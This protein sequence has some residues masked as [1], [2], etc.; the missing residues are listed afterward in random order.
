MKGNP[1]AD[2]ATWSV[3]FFRSISETSAKGLPQA[4]D[5]TKM[6]LTSSKGKVV[7]FSIQVGRASSCDYGC[8]WWGMGWLAVPVGSAVCH[9]YEYNL[10]CSWWRLLW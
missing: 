4:T 6:G 5:A 8:F 7:E 2:P 9:R 3:Q 1:E 10:V